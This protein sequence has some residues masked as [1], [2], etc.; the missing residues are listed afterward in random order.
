[1]DDAE[2]GLLL[3]GRGRR[4]RAAAARRHRAA[5]HDGRRGRHAER[6]LE[7][8]HELRELEDRELL[9]LVNDLSNSGHLKASSIRKRISFP[10]CL[11]ADRAYAA[12]P[13]PFSSLSFAALSA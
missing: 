3:L 8:L 6:R 1:D 2:R 10:A 12:A 13:P 4:G 7:L 9:D 11:F 5:H